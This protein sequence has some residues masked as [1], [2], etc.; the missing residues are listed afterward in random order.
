MTSEPHAK[1]IVN[2]IDELIDAKLG[3]KALESSDWGCSAALETNKV[4]QELVEL[5]KRRL[6]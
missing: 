6:V 4:K 3:E 1:E 5:F 2:K